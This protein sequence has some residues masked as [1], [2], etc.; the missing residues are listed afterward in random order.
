[1]LQYFASII[2]NISFL[3]WQWI[4]QDSVIVWQNTQ[5]KVCFPVMDC[6]SHWCCWTVLPDGV[7]QHNISQNWCNFT[8]LCA[9][10]SEGI[11]PGGPPVDFS[12]VFLGGGQNWW[13]MVFNTRS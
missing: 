2:Y 13:N 8:C 7:I 6:L 12:Q 3:I 9:W 5:C 10:T 11:F 4:R 1:M